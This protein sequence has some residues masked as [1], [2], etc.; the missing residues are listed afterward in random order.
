MM[1]QYTAA[2][3]TFGNSGWGHAVLVTLIFLA[4]V[5]S[6]L[7]P[8][9]VATILPRLAGHVAKRIYFAI[10]MAA[11]V[12]V[13]GLIGS[14]FLGPDFIGRASY[15]LW[16][17]LLVAM[18]MQSFEW[19]A[20]IHPKEVRP[21]DE[22][23]IVRRTRGA[24][25]LWAISAKGLQVGLSWGQDRFP[26]YVWLVSGIAVAWWRFASVM[27]VAFIVGYLIPVFWLTN[28]L[29]R[30]AKLVIRQDYR[31]GIFWFK[32]LMGIVMILEAVYF[33]GMA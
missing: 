29:E 18:A 2:M 4:G 30:L 22:K 15:I 12:I 3:N 21:S 27:T 7:V 6:S 9:T 13:V 14:R 31:R 23:P 19:I 25:R 20:F 32:R 16:A 1:E 24:K 8:E 11:S 5:V 26:I 28:R 17:I 33:L 10:G